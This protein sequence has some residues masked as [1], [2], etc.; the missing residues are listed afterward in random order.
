MP[1]KRRSGFFAAET[2]PQDEEA[3]RGDLEA[4]IVSRRSVPQDIGIERIEPNPFQARTTFDGIEELARA[5]RAH[6]FTSRLRVRPHP[7]RPN[8]FQL[9][10][11][12]RRLRAAQVAGLTEV[13]CEIAE[14]SDDEL[15]EIGLAEN[16]QRR[17]LE[18][19][20]EA[21]AFATFIEQRGYSIRRLAERIGKDKSYVDD[22]LAL[23]RAPSDVQ[24]MV[25]Q[26]PESLRAAREIAKLPTDSE[27]EELIAGVVAGE[28]N[29]QEVRQRVRAASGGR[30]K[31]VQ[32]HQQDAEPLEQVVSREAAD[33]QSILARWREV[34]AQGEAEQALISKQTE[35][36][37]QS[38]TTLLQDLKQ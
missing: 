11:G 25:E 22:R 36:V 16:I 12:E 32:P 37:L 9:V 38:I 35:K 4:L 24:Q 14:H 2:R 19:L 28:L 6:G 1:A 34:A 26:R 30:E 29:T 15:I 5:M 27:R 10:Y 8:A 17:D 20:E 7:Q 21:R 18:P 31:K 13:P 33:I 23:L 3:R